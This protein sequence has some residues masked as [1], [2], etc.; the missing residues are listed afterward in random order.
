MVQDLYPGQEGSIPGWITAL[1]GTVF[2]S[3]TTPATGCE[4][5]AVSTT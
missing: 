1:G 2:F 3:A 4:L 5:W